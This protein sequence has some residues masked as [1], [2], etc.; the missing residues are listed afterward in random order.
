MHKDELLPPRRPQKTA[1]CGYCCCNR[2]QAMEDQI[3]ELNEKNAVAVA[4]DVMQL[5]AKD[6][7]A[8]PHAAHRTRQNAHWRVAAAYIGR[9]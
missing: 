7:D 9:A 5:Q 1:A 6:T 4:V 3:R 2:A 8:P